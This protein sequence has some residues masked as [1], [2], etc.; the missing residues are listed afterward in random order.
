MLEALYLPLFLFAI[1][2][3]NAA[4]RTQGTKSALLYS[5][6]DTLGSLIRMLQQSEI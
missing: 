4:L 5:A 3:S 1:P 6:A 2:P